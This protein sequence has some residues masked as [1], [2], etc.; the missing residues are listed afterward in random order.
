MLLN[1]FFFYQVVRLSGRKSVNKYLYLSHTFPISPHLSDC[2]KQ[3]SNW[4]YHC[5]S[6]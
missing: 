3:N 5:W 4:A 6:V 1:L 2:W